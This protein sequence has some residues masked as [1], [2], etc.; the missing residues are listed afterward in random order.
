[1]RLWAIN[2]EKK[3]I[4]KTYKNTLVTR[5]KLQN[6]IKTKKKKEPITLASNIWKT[7]LL[8]IS[9]IIPPRASLPTP[10][11]SRLNDYRGSRGWLWKRYKYIYIYIYKIYFLLTFILKSNFKKTLCSLHLCRK[12]VDF[13][14][15][16]TLWPN[17]DLSKAR[18]SLC[19][20]KGNSPQN[21]KEK[22]QHLQQFLLQSKV[23]KDVRSLCSSDNKDFL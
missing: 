4:T 7:Q 14:K 19:G 10:H 9:L 1:M 18:N 16:S 21:L 11:S 15:C 8:K 3:K 22:A 13:A 2:L 5:F 23:A 12:L 6:T 17:T 20:I